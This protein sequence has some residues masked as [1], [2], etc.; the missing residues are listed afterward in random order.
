MQSHVRACARCL[1][2]LAAACSAVDGAP[3]PARVPRSAVLFVIGRDWHTEIGLQAADLDGSL[4]AIRNQFPGARTVLFGFGD[5]QYLTSR[6][7]GFGDMLRAAFPGPGALLVTGLRTTPAE[8]FGAAQV[9]QVRV[10]AAGL[11]RASQFLWAAFET[12]AG[13]RARSLGDGP[14]PG[15]L[16]YASG[17]TYALTHTCN[18]WTAEALQTAGAAVQ[19]NGVLLAAQVM[20]RARGAAALADADAADMP[21]K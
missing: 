2:L 8:A 13:G 15:S 18:T 9:V 11:A 16:F 4:A 5:R 21:G 3:D 6:Q 17:E 1:A 10:S 7:P 14:Y 20:A 19:A 12:G